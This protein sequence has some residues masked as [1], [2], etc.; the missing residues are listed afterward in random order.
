MSKVA[1]V[2]GASRG[3]GR[4]IALKLAQE[5]YD[6]VVNYNSNSQAADE[7]VAEI[8]ALGQKALA[9]Q[10]DISNVADTAKLFDAA[11]NEFGQV[12]A[13][14]NNAGLMITEP[15]AQVTEETFDRQFNIN[16]KGTFFMLKNAFEKLADNGSIV[17]I[18]TSV[19]G[20]MFPT[21]SVYTGTKGAVEQF[22]R[23]LA[24][25]FGTRQ[26]NINAIAPGPTGTELFLT[27]KSEEQINHLASMNAYNRLGTPDD[28]ANVVAMLVSPAGKWINGQTIRTNGGFI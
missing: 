3:I 10:A 1:I 28:I 9:V 5:G 26:I 23:Q 6:I 18:S 22:T 11:I 16:V 12:D 17:N 2:T 21:Y 24:K 13:L 15:I 19:V 14:I 25:E 20:Q 8:T 7:V 4:Q 27:G